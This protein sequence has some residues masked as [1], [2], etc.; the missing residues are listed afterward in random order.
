MNFTEKYEGI[1]G[2]L[3]PALEIKDLAEVDF[4]WSSQI[5]LV[6]MAYVVKI[7][8]TVEAANGIE[9]EMSL[10]SLIKGTLP[11]KVPE[12]VSSIFEPNLVAAAYKFIDGSMFTTQPVKDEIHALRADVHLS[13]NKRGL[14]AMQIGETLG[15]IHSIPQDLVGPVLEKYVTDKWEEKISSW[16]QECRITGEKGLY[17]DELRICNEFLDTLEEE[18]HGLNYSQKF[19][20]GDFGGWNMLFDP[21]SI[22]FQGLLDWADSRIGDPAKD[23]TEL[24]YDFGEPF[25]R[26]IL[27]HYGEER[28]PDIMERAKLYLKLAGFQDL[29][30]G[31]N[32]GSEFFIERGKRSILRELKNFS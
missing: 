32:T 7:P 18:F 17:P 3:F 11:V 27:L 6:N 14:I 24:I 21:V 29:E 8:K 30:Y 28:D 16:F 23:F 22:I 13:G 31:L 9:K 19:I 4:G 12:Y 5:L 1:L 2:K 25:S 15:S 26:E 20:H 10:T